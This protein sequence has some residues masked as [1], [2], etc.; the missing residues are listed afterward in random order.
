VGPILGTFAVA[1][2]TEV[3]FSCVGAISLGLAV[4]ALEH[5]NPPPP[6]TTAPTRARALARTPAII[7][8]FWII[9][10]EAC[11]IGATQTLLPL[12]LSRFGAT[13]VA[14]GVTFVLTSLLSASVATPIGRVVD[15]RGARL[16][17]C[18]GL[19]FAAISLAVL[20]LADTAFGLAIVTVIAVG[21]PLTAYTIPAMSVITDSA[22]RLG[23]P[24][25]F[26]TMLLNLAWA[27]GEMAGAPAA[28]TIS[29]ATSDGVALLL[30]S[31]LMI[32]T[33]PVVMRARLG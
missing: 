22:E 29:Q 11:T 5:P 23:V 17:L 3:V 26:A 2:G 1:A 24:L 4:W 7:V 32:L 18:A 12:R 8:G 30:L 15:R 25:A 19:L 6:D 16:P 20:P 14:I 31:L 13:G 33:L 10:L 28:A 21:G 9:L 27:S